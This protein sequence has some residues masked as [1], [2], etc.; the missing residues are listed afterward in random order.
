MKRQAR[1]LALAAAM[2]ACGTAQACR[3]PAEPGPAAA[4]ARAAGVLTGEVLRVD[5]GTYPGEQQALVGVERAWK[6][7]VDSEQWVHT[8]T[9]CA[10]SFTAGTHLLLYVFR[11]SQQRL[12][13]RVC[14][15]NRPLDQAQP[16]LDWLERRGKPAPVGSR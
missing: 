10:Y 16:H 1:L 9:T 15:G 3:C 13:T 6:L 7:P 5:A 12:Q 2:M 4:Y 11:D 14:M 8:R